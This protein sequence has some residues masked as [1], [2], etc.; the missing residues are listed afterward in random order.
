[1]TSIPYKR[2]RD[3]TNEVGPGYYS[4]QEP[5]PTKFTLS[6]ST[7]G[8]A[9]FN[10]T[11]NR[12]PIQHPQW[13]FPDAGMY[14]SYAAYNALNSKQDF[15]VESATFKTT[16]RDNPYYQPRIE[17][18]PAPGQ[19]EVQKN[20]SE[21]FKLAQIRNKRRAYQKAKEQSM[22]QQLLLQAAKQHKSLSRYLIESDP[23]FKPLP[24]PLSKN[25]LPARPLKKEIDYSIPK[26]KSQA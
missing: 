19:Y 11:L 17:M 23:N 22:T 21:A 12:F 3:T 10:S 8:S 5:V 2:R 6:T 26:F 13:G 4:P 7:K 24:P 1:M 9:C 15:Q 25:E 14:D 20:Y 16:S 18:T